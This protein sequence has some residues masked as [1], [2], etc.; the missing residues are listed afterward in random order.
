MY[1]VS[2]WGLRQEE[3][4]YGFIIIQSYKVDSRHRGATE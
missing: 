2:T 1:N 4:C 3:M